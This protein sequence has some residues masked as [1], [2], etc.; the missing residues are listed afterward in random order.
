MV[1][2][3]VEV[4]QPVRRGEPLLEVETD[5]SIL[6]VESAVT[7]T[8]QAIAVAAG[9]RGGGRPG[10]RD[11]R[12]STE[13]A[14]APSRRACCPL[15]MAAGDDRCGR[16]PASGGPPDW[17]SPRS[18]GAGLDRRDRPARRF[19]LRAEPPGAG[20]GRGVGAPVATSA[21]HYAGVSAA[22]FTGGWS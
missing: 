17:Q 22:I 20:I 15:S 5:K 2:W 11:V 18:R 6:V 16:G 7:G 10:H 8:L 13:D 21:G 3:L 4:G 19:V 12:T 14:S 9:E 1:K